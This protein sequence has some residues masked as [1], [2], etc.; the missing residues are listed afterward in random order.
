[1]EDNP[2]QQGRSRPGVRE[3]HER[4]NGADVRDLVTPSLADPGVFAHVG[5][6]EPRWSEDR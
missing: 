5:E 2:L 1:M 6:T 4:S 3:R